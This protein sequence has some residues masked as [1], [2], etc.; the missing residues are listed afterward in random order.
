M[1]FRNTKDV[2]VI[3]IRRSGFIGSVLLIGITLMNLFVETGTYDY[4]LPR[5]LIA[6]WLLALA[7]SSYFNKWVQD[8]GIRVLY[9]IFFVYNFYGIALVAGRLMQIEWLLKVNYN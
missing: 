6:V 7:V 9:L 5:V 4:P 3:Y 1:T 2:D 8:Y